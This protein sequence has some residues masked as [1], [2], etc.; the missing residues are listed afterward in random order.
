MSALIDCR[1]LTKTYEMGDTTIN[2]LAG[3]SIT[4]NQGEY[5]AVMGASGSGKS[6]F[7]N[8][9]G[10][11]DTPTSGELQVAGNRLSQLNADALAD[12]RSGSIGF[13]FQQFNLLPRT[14]A[15]ENVALPL[16]YAGVPAAER[17]RRALARL[18][19]V[20]LAERSHHHPKQLSGGQQQR[21]AIAR[22]LVNDPAIILADEPTGALDSRTSEEVMAIFDQLNREGITIILVTHE[23]DVADHAKRQ[24]VFRDGLVVEDRS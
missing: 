8:L 23:Q 3:V 10:A 2:A 20:G 7:M 4:I 16:V 18:E 13:V 1:N 5:V 15:V 9:L 12:F 19:Q 6:T 22:A 11:L 17:N 21:V 14:P 24:L